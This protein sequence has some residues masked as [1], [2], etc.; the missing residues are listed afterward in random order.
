MNEPQVNTVD[1]LMDLDPL[2]LTSTDI[3]SIIAYHRKARAN[4]TG[5]K[6]KREQGPKVDISEVMK[7][8]GGAPAPV[9]TVIRR[10]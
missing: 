6:A 1:M 10:R 4:S 8:M 2:S 7:A 5:G 3:D 9:A